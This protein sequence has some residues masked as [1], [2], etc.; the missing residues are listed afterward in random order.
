[1]S[2]VYKDIVID[3]PMSDNNMKGGEEEMGKISLDSPILH[4]WKCE[5]CDHEWIPRS[6]RIPRMCPNCNSITWDRPI[7]QENAKQ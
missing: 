5:K 2:N 7:E 1:M 3:I 4:K 6:E